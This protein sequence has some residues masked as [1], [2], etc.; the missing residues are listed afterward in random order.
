M[1]KQIMSVAIRSQK[2]KIKKHKSYYDS[3]YDALVYLNDHPIPL[4]KYRIA[5]NKNVIFLLFSYR[6]ITMVTDRNL[7][8]SIDHNE[9]PHYT[10][11][12]KGI[13]FI[14]RFQS[15]QDLLI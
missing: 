15:L 1:A 14:R 13:E 6:M 12:P 9:V 10:I 5:S 4:T 11:S 8:S 3:L 7:L 2:S